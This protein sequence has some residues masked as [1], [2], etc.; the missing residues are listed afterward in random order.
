MN[1]RI[2]ILLLDDQE[3]H[4]NFIKDAILLETSISSEKIE[5]QIF[6][7]FQ[8][9]EKLIR[10][11]INFKYAGIKSRK[12]YE[13]SMKNLIGN[14]PSDRTDSFICVVDVNWGYSSLDHLGIDFYKEFL[15]DKVKLE[16]TILIS[17]LDRHELKEE[18]NG[19][20]FIRKSYRDNKGDIEVLG[21]LFKEAIRDSI[22]ALP[23]IINFPNQDDEPTIEKATV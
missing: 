1:N 10:T 3:T 6:Y 11:Y 14:I 13:E 12:K 18:F 22:N 9:C 4:Y 15:L 8:N 16:N 2:T 21:E 5:S 23:V 17:I 7:D 20:K 19:L